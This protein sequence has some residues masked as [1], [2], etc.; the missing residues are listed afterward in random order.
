MTTKR[1]PLTQEQLEDAHRLKQIFECKKQE[2]KKNKT[3]FSQETVASKCGWTQGGLGHYLNGKIA[4][5]LDSAIKLAEAMDINVS[6]FSPTLA[7]QIANAPIKQEKITARKKGFIPV[8]G[9]AQMGSDGY[10]TEY[11]GLGNSGDGYLEVHNAKPKMYA[12]RAIGTSM[13]PA[14]R[15]GW[16]VIFDPDREPMAGEYVHVVLKGGQNMIKEFISNQHGILTLMSVNGMERL[17]FN[18]ADVEVLNAFTE[19]QPP[20][21]LLLDIPEVIDVYGENF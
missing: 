10:W 15:S 6:D 12:I 16:F 9:S 18:I 19:I 13:F 20:S 11:D 8:R 2:A 5:N 1:K 17:S 3:H 4:L 21:R 7:G 14:I